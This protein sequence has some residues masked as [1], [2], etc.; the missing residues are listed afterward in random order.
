MP[1]LIYFNLYTSG[2]SPGWDEGHRC[3]KNGFLEFS[4]RELLRLMGY[5]IQR[6]PNLNRLVL[7][8]PK[9]FNTIDDSRSHMYDFLLAEK[10]FTEIPGDTTW[11]WEEQQIRRH[12]R[13]GV[14]TISV[15]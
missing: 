14:E 13:N 6:H 12:P 7:P 3:W 5:V 11:N 1:N 10:S 2:R 15:G 9:N 4:Q 8:V